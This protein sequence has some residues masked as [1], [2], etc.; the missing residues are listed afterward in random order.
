[1]YA[2][3]SSVLVPTLLPLLIMTV[4]TAGCAFV[5][6]S[7]LTITY[8]THGIGYCAILVFDA[9]ITFG[10]QTPAHKYIPACKA[11]LILTNILLT[12]HSRQSPKR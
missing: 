9:A 8:P 12:T 2:G 1:M 4:L 11:V 7:E 5:L 6:D 3:T 10:L